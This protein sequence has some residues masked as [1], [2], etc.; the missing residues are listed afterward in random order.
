MLVVIVILLVLATLAVMFV[1]NIQGQQRAAEG[2]TQLQS[3]LAI[4]RQ[5]ALRDQTAGGIRLLPGATHSQWV[6]EAQYIVQPED[7]TGGMLTTLNPPLVPTPD[8]YKL[9]FAFPVGTDLYGGSPSDPTLWT[10]QPG[11]YIELFGSGLV[12][13]VKNILAANVLELVSPVPYPIYTPTGNYRIIR[14]P[15]PL[16]GA[17]KLTL[18]T[19]IAI[20]LFTNLDGAPPAAPVLDPP[21]T[22]VPVGYNNPIV[23]VIDPSGNLVGWDI[24]F[25]P[26]G[27][28]IGDQA[29]SSSVILWV[30]DVTL[31]IYD[32]GTQGIVGTPTLVTIYTR[33]GLTAAHPVDESTGLTPGSA[34]L[35]QPYN[36]TRDGRSSGL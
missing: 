35:P 10:V 2:G 16:E 15:R 17:D 12:R 30:R 21:I 9:V 29:A 22:G 24:L 28:I 20:D 33:S 3:W 34:P 8:L 19:D 14:R 11:D 32:A 25:A 18:P 1:P 36:F 27:R 5:R 26:S 13:R 23:P 4:A 6:T 31:P 7:F